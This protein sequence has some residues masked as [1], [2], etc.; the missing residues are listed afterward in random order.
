MKQN[1]KPTATNA[2]PA[3]SCTGVMTTR[4]IITDS[5]YVAALC[6]FKT[7][8]PAAYPV[9][10]QVKIGDML[11]PAGNRTPV[12]RTVDSHFTD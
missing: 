3:M 2:D 9:Y 12:F 8:A 5:Q 11:A 10:T 4:E 1:L 7:T 6:A